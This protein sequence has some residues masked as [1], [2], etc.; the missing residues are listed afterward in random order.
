MGVFDGRVAR[1]RAHM[2]DKGFDAAIVRNNADLRWLTGAERTFD[3]EVAHTAFIT[4]DGLWLHTDSRYYNTF[5]E[6]LGPDTPWIIDMETTGH[7][8]WC[9]ERIQ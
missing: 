7:P 9:T 6:R 2:A 8:A 1:F 5:C 3:L 4:Q